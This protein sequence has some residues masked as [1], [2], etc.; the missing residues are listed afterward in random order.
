MQSLMYNSCMVKTHQQQ[1]LD[2]YKNRDLLIFCE[3][4]DWFNEQ[5]IELLKVTLNKQYPDKDWY[6]ELLFWELDNDMIDLG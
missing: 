3:G 5:A 6:R 2:L 4:C 1:L